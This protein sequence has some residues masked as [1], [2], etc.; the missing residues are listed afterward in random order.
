M[1]QLSI[2][3]GYITNS[4]KGVAISADGEFAILNVGQ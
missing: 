4:I 3:V 2:P 1:R